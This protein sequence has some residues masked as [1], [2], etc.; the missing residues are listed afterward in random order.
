MVDDS[1][2][3]ESGD[4]DDAENVDAMLGHPALV[5]YVHPNEQF[6]VTST[7]P[8]NNQFSM[9]AG[10]A[11]V[12]ATSLN[13]SDGSERRQ[14]MLACE[15]TATTGISLDTDGTGD[16]LTGT[17]YVFLDLNLGSDSAQWNVIQQ[18]DGTPP[19]DTSLLITSFDIQDEGGEGSADS[20][21]VLEYHN[22]APDHI[23]ET[24]SHPDGG[25]V[26]LGASSFVDAGHNEV[27][28]P[29]VVELSPTDFELGYLSDDWD[30]Y[31]QTGAGPNEVIELSNPP[32]DSNYAL[33]LIGNNRDYARATSLGD[34]S[35]YIQAGD[36]VTLYYFRDFWSNEGRIHFGEDTQYT[37]NFAN[38]DNSVLEIVTPEESVSASGS[39]TTFTGEWYQITIDVGLDGS[40]SA[41]SRPVDDPADSSRVMSATSDVE[42]E[43]GGGTLEFSFN[44]WDLDGTTV[45]SSQFTDV[46]I[47]RLAPE[48]FGSTAAGTTELGNEI[49]PSGG[50][51]AGPR[52]LPENAQ[53]GELATAPVTDDATQG[54]TSLLTLLRSGV[55]P[56]A[57]FQRSFD[58][59]GGSYG[60]QLQTALGKFSRKDAALSWGKTALSDT[61]WSEVTD[62]SGVFTIGLVDNPR[63]A[64]IVTDGTSG[65][66]EYGGVANPTIVSPDALDHFAIT[67]KGVEVQ[68]VQNFDIMMG[69]SDADVTAGNPRSNG[70]GVMFEDNLA[71]NTTELA[72]VNGGSSSSVNG[73]T[74]SSFSSTGAGTMERITLAYDGSTARVEAAAADGQYYTRTLEA[75]TSG[76][77]RPFIIINDNDFEGSTDG[78]LRVDEVVLTPRTGVL[79]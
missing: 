45:N 35:A 53:R 79:H 6:E 57:Y 50:I 26:S 3:I 74:A 23:A 68:N 7:D 10:K 65:T 33:K 5:D 17:Q 34:Q 32:G 78:I 24:L 28:V 21:P 41:E 56:A 76:L 62:G 73:P 38:R 19:N 43:I 47:Y 25:D 61:E 66:E 60:H 72:V 64:E 14:L 37:V 49:A 69:V 16:V 18:A 22:R 54:D 71:N 46:R 70:N 30:S 2:L 1:I 36:T 4:P 51:H 39:K 63:R 59:D 67:F 48:Y 20:I 8:D 29:Q 12:S 40:I 75:Q 42:R 15:K 44:T 55:H 31:N 13:T 77:M 52:E 27:E 9:S 11:Y 58:G